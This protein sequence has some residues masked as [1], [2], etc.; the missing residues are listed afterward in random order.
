MLYLKTIIGIL[1]LKYL[2]VVFVILISLQF[3]IVMAL[4]GEDVHGQGMPPITSSGLN[5]KVSA[6]VILH[7]GETQHNI[8]GGTRPGGGGNLFH[9]FGEFNVP[10]NNVA[11]FLNDAALPTNNILSR[12]TGD[13][14][15]NILGTIKTEGFGNANLFLMN[16]AGIVFGPDATLNVGGSSYFTTADYVRLA[17]GVQFTALPG[18]QNAVLSIAPVGAFGFLQSNPAPLS[19]S[20][21][22]LTVSDGQ[23]LSLV[24]GDVMIG[25]GLKASVGQIAVASVASPGEVLVDTFASA[26]NING[27]SFNA[28]GNVSLLE[29]AILDVSGDAAGTVIIRGGN[30]M[31]TNATISADTVDSDGV[32]LAVDIQ[33]S[34]DLT[35]T[36]TQGSP[37]ITARTTGA[38]NAGEVRILSKD[39]SAMSSSLDLFFP[40]I[41]THTSGSGTAGNVNLTATGTIQ[42]TGNNAGLMHFI[43]SGTIGADGGHGGDVVIAA[44]HLQLT[45]ADISTGDWTALNLDFALGSGGNLTITADTVQLTNSFL[46]TD[47]FFNGKAGDI[48][49][50]ARDIQL[51]D[52]SELRVSE[53]GG[54]GAI[55]ITADRFF[56]DSS[57]I[58]GETV[59]GVGIGVPWEG[60][61]IAANRVEFRN[62]SQIQQQTFGDGAAGNIRITATDHMIVSDDPTAVG[63]LG[64]PGGLFTNSFGDIGLGDQGPAGNIFINTSRIEMSGGARIDSTTQSSGRG[65][66]VT[67]MATNGV[68]LMGARPLFK[69]EE[70]DSVLGSTRPSGIFSR[71]V[72]SEG[73][74]CTGGC[75]DAGNISISTGSLTVTDGAAINS[76]TTSS[77]QGGS[78]YV[79]ASTNISIAGILDDGTPGGVFSQTTGTDPGSGV[80]GIIY[81]TAGDSF[82]LKDGATVSASS[83]GPADAGSIQLTATDTILID[84][85]S[86]T[87][88]AAQASGGNIKLTA[89]DLI[90]LNDSTISSSVQGSTTTVGGDISVDPDFIILQNSQILAKAVEGQGGNISLI[91]NNAVLVDP[92]SV[93]DASSALG[94]SGSVDIQAPIQNLSG[95][96][97]PLPEETTPVTALYGARCAAGSGGHFS[98]FVDSKAGSLSSTPGAFLASP[99]LNLAASTQAVADSSDGLQGSV[100]LTASIAPLVLGHAG[101][102][103]TACP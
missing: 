64:R 76:G 1:F 93:L 91:A 77:G 25:S 19:V 18:A 43:E 29:G 5:T 103:T 46:V 49:I 45:D 13:N 86:V 61:T 50:S 32:P 10:T 48:D 16:P 38:G 57:T 17:D 82:F 96:L 26:P 52:L 101:E 7:S 11:N 80:G 90:R 81:L 4:V 67:I 53:W 36:D 92:L 65:G 100:I 70:V 15:S 78:I 20:G 95:T 99:L 42:A 41:D 87:T 88:E 47:G 24:G 30:L 71:T 79:N 72:G 63:T 31:M 75:G 60:V 51:N 74:S 12:V 68:S 9:S 66:D 84:G 102:P 2:R 73:V 97:A 55:H 39:L 62:G 85:A 56:M 98:T 35:M 83:R 89:E 3:G 69:F 27:Q 37:L 33:L 58:N 21:S 23:T 54:G 34:G 14:P 6:P 94:V 44:N 59:E 22:T 8:I 28:M 40:L